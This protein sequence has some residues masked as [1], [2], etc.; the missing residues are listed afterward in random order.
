MDAPVDDEI[1]C[2]PHEHEEVQCGKKPMSRDPPGRK[3]S[4]RRRGQCNGSEQDQP[5]VRLRLLSPQ[6]GQRKRN[7]KRA[8]VI[9]RKLEIG[10]RAPA[11]KVG[12]SETR[13]HHRCPQANDN[14]G[15]AQRKPKPAGRAMPSY[16][17]HPDQQRLH[18]YER[19]P[20]AKDERMG[21]QKGWTGRLRVDQVLLYGLAEAEE[22]N[23]RDQQCHEEIEGLIQQ[24]RRFHRH[25]KAP[26]PE[27]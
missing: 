25:G 20:A 7:S 19:D 26:M 12:D 8:D 6:D 17:A 24:A 22:H 16:F 9:E 27:C 23:G 14:H 2:H 1:V 18:D 11:M 5:P 15:A 3:P 13:H 4:P 21:I 10:H